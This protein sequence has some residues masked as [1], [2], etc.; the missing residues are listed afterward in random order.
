[1]PRNP[2]RLAPSL[3]ASP[4]RRTPLKSTILTSSS[5][6]SSSSSSPW[7]D[8]FKQKCLQRARQKR[9]ERLHSKR[10]RL[11]PP[12]CSVQ[13]DQEM[14]N[15][16]TFMSSS[17]EAQELI[18]EELQRHYTPSSQHA[19]LHSFFQTPPVQRQPSMHTFHNQETISNVTMG[20]Y[21]DSENGDHHHIFN[22]EELF[23]LMQEVEDELQREGKI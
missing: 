13:D 3:R 11:P 7:K 16:T 22:E 8:A 4:H 1:M 15:K 18:Q 9:Q 10:I 21:R 6:P 14:S 20:E 5:S 2:Q 12:S 17:L 19:P 23:Q